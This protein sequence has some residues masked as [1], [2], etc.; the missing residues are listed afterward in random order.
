MEKPVSRVRVG[1]G[2]LLIGLLLCA[3]LTAHAAIVTD[4]YEASVPVPDQSA[5]A[6]NVA[7][8]QALAAVLVKVTGE[9]SA[10]GVPALASL[11]QN[12]SQ[13]LQ[14][15]RYEQAP[16]ANGTPALTYY[17]L[18][19]VGTPAIPLTG[20][21]LSARFDP[22]VVDQAVRAAHEP[23]WGRE[24][25]ATLVWIA[26][27]DGSN[28]SIV[29][30]SG[31]SAIVQAMNS[32]A[33]QRGVTLMFPA[34]DAVDQQAIGIPDITEDN[35]ARI[36]QA[37]QRY[38]PDATLIGSIYMTTPG[39]YAARWQLTVGN[40]TASW[41]TPPNNL[42]SVAA[43]GVQTAADNYAKWFALAADAVGQDGVTLSVTGIS[44]VDAYAKVLAYLGKLTPVKSVQVTRV[45]NHTVYF[46][47]DTRGSLANLQQAV[48][49]GDLLKT[50]APAAA[51]ANPPSA[52]LLQFQ[53]AP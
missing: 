4:L 27:Q 41:T 25:P 12:P 29:S 44:G 20:L 17:D 45:D 18:T 37:S 2:G 19:R 28:V 46:S 22:E 21:L 38:K 9:R 30:A 50:A 13:F 1:F 24:R 39:Q 53:Y 10:G 11:L 6:R 40:Q 36:Q 51:S 32:A 31:N 35:T 52:T 43:D 15:Y 48:L 14:Q 49:L 5:G 23:L 3:N 7:L 8:Q 16:G 33:Q 47:L 42:T 26:F 34:M